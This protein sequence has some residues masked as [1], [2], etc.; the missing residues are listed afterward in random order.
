MDIMLIFDMTS[1]ISNEQFTTFTESVAS[2]VETS[3]P[4]DGS[5]LAVVQ[6]AT[7]SIVHSNFNSQP[8]IKDTAQTMRTIVRE[9]GAT[10]TRRAFLDAWTKVNNLLYFFLLQTL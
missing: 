4:R 7:R 9:F 10:W 6:Y 8:S 5:R 2:I 3:F 1:T